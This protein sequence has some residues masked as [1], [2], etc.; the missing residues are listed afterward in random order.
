ML[1]LQI[2]EQAA[3]ASAPADRNGTVTASEGSSRASADFEDAVL[4]NSAEFHRSAWS[5]SLRPPSAADRLAKHTFQCCRL[6][7][8][9]CIL[10]GLVLTAVE[11][12]R[13]PGGIPSWKPREQ[14]RR[15]RSS[16]HMPAPC[17]ATWL[18]AGTCRPRW[19][20][21][22]PPRADRRGC[23]VHPLRSRSII[24]QRLRCL[25]AVSGSGFGWPGR[26]RWTR[27]WS[28]LGP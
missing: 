7:S 25:V 27:P 15:R 2:A 19:V 8:V 20:L 10:Q 3:N 13:M 24:E 9:L 26:R 14:A 18:P 11:P 28:F 22:P 1:G 16:G 5:S 6:A 21:L 23:F 12:V 17:R 4:Q